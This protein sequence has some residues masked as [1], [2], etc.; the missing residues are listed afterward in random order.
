V[1]ETISKYAANI[2]CISGM[3][4]QAH[5][6]HVIQAPGRMN[7]VAN[8]SP[9]KELQPLE[10]TG[11]LDTCHCILG[12]PKLLSSSGLLMQTVEAPAL[13][14]MVPLLLKGL[15]ESTPIQRKSCVIITNMSK[16]VNSPVD[17]VNF[18]PK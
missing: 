4:E 8:A 12:V 2:Y 9:C 5:C 13:A 14:V 1:K 3:Q 18:L 11:L 17:A 10:P 16:L 15:K 7:A 6:L